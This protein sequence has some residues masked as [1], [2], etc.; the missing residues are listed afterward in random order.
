M[1][2]HDIQFIGSFT[3][4]RQAPT[5]ATPEYAFIGRSNVGKSSLINSLLERKEIARVSKKPGK[6]QQLNFFL[7]NENWHIVDLPGYGYAQVSKKERTKWEHMVNNY[8]IHRQQ[9]QCAFVLID[10]N[11]PPQ[12]NDL[13][14]IN[15]LGKNSIPFVIVF[16]KTDRLTANQR[17]KNV[18]RFKKTMLQDWE[19]LPQFFVTSSV[20]NSGREEILQFIEEITNQYYGTR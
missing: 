10:A 5:E 2:I 9:L 13:A 15:W 3:D 20:D 1:T 6:T 7:I 19:H 18:T 11:V 8:F 4:H 17:N 14:F 12:K 16:T